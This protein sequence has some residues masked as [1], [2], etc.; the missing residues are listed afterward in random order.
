MRPPRVACLKIIHLKNSPPA[1][2]RARRIR[3]QG[4]EL[5]GSEPRLV[6]L[7]SRIIYE[8]AYVS[9]ASEVANNIP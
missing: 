2:P 8:P 4:K 6:A 5:Y 7:V 3:I 1:Q 9:T